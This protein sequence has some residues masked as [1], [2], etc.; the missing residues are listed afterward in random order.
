MTLKADALVRTLQAMAFY[1]NNPSSPPP[2]PAA[3]TAAATA[4]PV[5]PFAYAYRATFAVDGWRFADVSAEWRRQGILGCPEWRVFDNSTWALCESYPQQVPTDHVL[6][7]ASPACL[8]LPSHHRRTA[9]LV[10]S[11]ASW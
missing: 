3:T 10:V 7:T 2:A 4:L 1:A 9:H 5:L 11:C 8:F 6:Y